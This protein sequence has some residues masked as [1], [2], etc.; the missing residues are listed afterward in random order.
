[1]KTTVK[2][3]HKN[4]MLLESYIKAFTIEGE[5]ALSDRN[6]IMIKGG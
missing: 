2:K 3:N 4:K 1:M 6:I 5:I